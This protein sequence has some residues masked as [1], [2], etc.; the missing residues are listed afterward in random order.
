[1]S[2]SVVLFAQTCPGAQAEHVK[3]AAQLAFCK[4]LTVLFIG[5]EDDYYLNSYS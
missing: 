1:M 5:A 4:E 2:V 3:G